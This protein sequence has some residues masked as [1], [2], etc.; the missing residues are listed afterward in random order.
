[1]SVILDALKKL[2]REKLF[3]KRGTANIAVEILRPDLTHPGKRLPISIIIVVVAAAVAAALTYGVM[4]QFGVRS[5]S[6]PLPIKT[7][8]GTSQQATPSSPKPEVTPKASHPASVSFHGTNRQISASV[9]RV[10]V[11]KVQ[12]EVNRVPAEPQPPTEKKER[13]DIKIPAEGKKLPAPLIDKKQGQDVII[14][15]E[16][17][18]TPK[19]TPEPAT[20]TTAA[21]P[22]SLKVSAIV[23]YEDATRRFA[24]INGVLARE[25]SFVEGAKVVEI[26][27]TSVRLS[28]NGQYF[29]LSMSK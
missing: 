21:N 25:G 13:A 16:V 12:E 10:S 14:P 24:M 27:P 19:K 17:D 8:S 6:S 20:A 26:N 29:E 15:K 9:P 5:K 18:T 4:S 11:P 3:R 2:D 23:W 1:M 7:V 28:H 22:E